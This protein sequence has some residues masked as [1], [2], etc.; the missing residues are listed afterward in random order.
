[1]GTKAIE[2]GKLVLNVNDL[3][4]G[5]EE[6]TGADM[7]IAEGKARQVAPTAPDITMTTVYAA[8][9]ASKALALPYDKIVGL[10]ARDYMLMAGTVRNFLFAEYAS[11]ME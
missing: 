4:S 9:V 1:M 6:L 5:L 2:T 11:I 10:S 3:K 8:Y 7:I